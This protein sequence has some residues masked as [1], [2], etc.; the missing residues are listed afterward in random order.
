MFLLD[1]FKRLFQ[2]HR[3]GAL[4]YIILNIAILYLFIGL[5]PLTNLLWVFIAYV[6]SLTVS[7]SPVGEVLLRI[8]NHAWRIKR[9][10]HIERLQPIFDR[11]YAKAKEKSPQINKSIRLYMTKSP[12]INAFALGRR[13]IAVTSGALGQSDEVLE[14]LLGHEFGH[15][16]NRDT[17]FLILAIMGNLFLMPV[18]WLLNIIAGLVSGLLGYPKSVLGKI[19]FWLL[20]LP[21]RIWT[22]IGVM[23]I[24]ASGRQSEFHADRYS[25]ELGY[26]EG[27]LRF[28]NS[29]GQ[30]ESDMNLLEM[31]KAT[32]PKTDSRIANLMTL[33]SSS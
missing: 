15:I 12:A 32:H 6:L 10:D 3:L 13:T 14:G 30:S 33:N 17:D 28:F 2:P 20:T 8:T 25:A 27:L 16:A 21:Q 31:L 19:L 26:G 1:F 29:I 18:F 23:L 9:P 7:L 4:L 24:L 11:V 5:S 22:W